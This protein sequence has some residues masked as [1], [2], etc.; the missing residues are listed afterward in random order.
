[1]GRPIMPTIGLA[2]ALLVTA[3]PVGTAAE[4]TDVQANAPALSTDPASDASAIFPTNTQIAAALAVNPTDSRY[5]IAGAEDAQRQPACAPGP[6]QGLAL[7]SDCSLLPDAGTSGVYTSEDGGSTWT[8]HGVLDDQPGWSDAG[9]VS[10][11]HPVIAYGPRP[12]PDGSG[13]SYQGGTRAYYA[14]RAT[15]EGAD[16][17][18]YIVVSWS[19]DNGMSWSAPVIGTKTSAA[20][21]KHSISVDKNPASP[22]FGHLYLTWTESRSATGTDPGAVM[23]A[24][25]GDGA[26]TFTDPEQL[27]PVDTVDIGDGRHGPSSTVGP[28]GTVYVAFKHETDQ[29]VTVSRDGGATWTRPTAISP[30]TDIADPIPGANF[31]TNSFPAIAADPRLGSQTVYAAWA[32]HTDDG[33]RVVV[34]ESSDAGMSWSEPVQVSGTEGYAFFPSLA[35]APNGRVDLGYQALTA[36]DPDTFG[37]GNATI[38]AYYVSLANDGFWGQPQRV[39]SVSSDPAVSA[40]ANLQRQSWGDYTVL[41]SDH[42][43]VWFSY[44]DSRNGVGCDDVDAY[45]RD[46]VDTDESP[47]PPVS[48][49]AQFGNTDVFVAVLTAPIGDDG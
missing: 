31:G 4:S 36:R 1:M 28:D 27:S 25:S 3:A 23:V 48:C 7:R 43:G 2:V 33:G 24:V 49:P 12:K 15:V 44:T 17:G 22:Y 11:G 14:S 16:G 29:A 9:V 39:S 30:V 21:D 8:D 38:D 19:D 41:V 10:A 34:A 47:A 26:S 6:G 5:V 42:A 37:V 18:E 45:Q 32:T 40:Q 20:D 46:L 13:F 35:V